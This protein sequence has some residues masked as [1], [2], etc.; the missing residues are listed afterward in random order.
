MNYTNII[1]PNVSLLPFHT[2]TE[3]NFDQLLLHILLLRR[4]RDFFGEGHGL[5]YVAK[6]KLEKGINRVKFMC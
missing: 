2:R 4:S 5:V 1:N 3:N 6:M